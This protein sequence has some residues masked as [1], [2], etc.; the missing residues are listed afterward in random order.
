M[1]ELP[2]RALALETLPA[3]SADLAAET[4]RLLSRRAQAARRTARLTALAVARR[5]P[6]GAYLI[7]LHRWL[8]RLY[9]G[10]GP[11]LSCLCVDA[12]FY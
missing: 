8:G 7:A 5:A 9:L 3:L 2:A 11:I 1:H 6:T 4:K 10:F 12:L